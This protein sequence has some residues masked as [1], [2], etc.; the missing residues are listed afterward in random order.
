MAAVRD[1]TG[2]IVSLWEP[3]APS[4]AP[5]ADAIGGLFGTSCDHRRVVAV[6]SDQRLRAGLSEAEVDALRATLERMR[7]NVTGD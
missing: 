5:P 6:A 7:A 3:R 2:A 4:C 1:P